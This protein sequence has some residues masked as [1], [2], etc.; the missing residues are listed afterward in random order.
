MMSMI[1][2]R[3]VDREK[4]L[5]NLLAFVGRYGHQ[6]LSVTMNLPVTLLQKFAK[7]LVEFL[8]KENKSTSLEDR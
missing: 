1:Y 5:I 2:S 7:S 4:Q 3:Y 6:P 8:E